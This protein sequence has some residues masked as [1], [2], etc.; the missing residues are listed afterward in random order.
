M[1]DQIRAIAARYQKTKEHILTEEATKT[2]LVLPFLSALGYDVYDPLEVVPEFTADL[3]IKKGEKID[4][5][6][7]RNGA[8]VM[9]VECKW[10]G[11]VLSASNIS[12]LYRYFNACDCHLGVLTNG[13]EYQFFSDTDNI[14]KMDESPF[15]KFNLLNDDDVQYA[16]LQKLTKQNMEISLI[17]QQAH[18]LKYR[19][20]IMRQLINYRQTPTEGFIRALLKDIDYPLPRIT[21]ALVD[22]FEPLVKDAFNLFMREEISAATNVA[23]PAGPPASEAPVWP[24][25]N[26]EID[27]TGSG[28]VT[29]PIEIA[30][31][32][33]IKSLVRE[34]MS[35]RRV[36]MRDAR[37]YCSVLLDNNNRKPICRMY[38]NN[39]ERLR[40]GFFADKK[41]EIIPIKSVD[42]IYRYADRL[43][44][45]VL[46]YDQMGMEAE[47]PAGEA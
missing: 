29:T 3:G 16:E 4:Y 6:V 47:M 27:G 15:F 25:P 44:E 21:K 11:A 35:P 43:K 8:V 34:V 23:F 14:N 10:S 1:Q 32:V 46:S 12:Q 28:I 38:F 45:T 20:A 36:I 9:L 37:S 30:G 2:S 13:L 39:P 18:D 42:D 24:G 19:Q 17:S 31:Y 40:L 41:E 22:S 33:T 26:Q 5:A 7:K